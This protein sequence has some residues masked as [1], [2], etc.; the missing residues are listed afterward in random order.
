MTALT[1][2]EEFRRAWRVPAAAM[3]TAFFISFFWY[4]LGV[5]IAPLQQAFGWSASVISGWFFFM[6]ITATFIAPF[7]G[8][9]ADRYG[10]R[11]L[12]FI[13]LPL[14]G[15]AI[16]LV[17]LLG[18]SVPLFYLS[19][20]LVGCFNIAMPALARAVAGC[21][22]SARGLALAIVA[23]G[24]G[25]SSTVGPRL[26]QAVVD[27]YGWRAGWLFMGALVMV[28]LPLLYAWLHERRESKSGHVLFPE[29]GLTAREARRRQAFW[30]IAATGCLWGLTMGCS[31]H[32]I[33]FLT[34]SGLSRAAAANLMVYFG[35]G[36]M[37]GKIVSGT[38]L[39]RIHPAYV[40]SVVFLAS[41]VALASLGLFQARYALAAVFT[42]GA[43]LGAWITLY[44]FCAARFFGMRAYGEITNWVAVGYNIGWAVGPVLFA[45]LLES[46]G[47]YEVPFLVSAAFSAAGGVCMLLLLRCPAAAPAELP[48]IHEERTA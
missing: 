6:M 2:P 20:V 48:V 17:G 44:Y 38:L 28:P 11:R 34:A 15:A 47:A 42:V 35:I 22:S 31:V 9:L 26:I 4:S 46:S 7:S 21:F 24:I 37:L 43:T 14:H 10:V 1:R 3:V 16:A 39:D 30:L 40:C 18:P 25:F 36:A 12:L 29:S 23:L 41:A 5:F 32:F 27:R 8:R 19:A 45:L 13:C 33:P